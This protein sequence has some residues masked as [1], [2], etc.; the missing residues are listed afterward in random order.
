[1]QVVH[2][3]EDNAGWIYLRT[4]LGAW[5]MTSVIHY[6]CGREDMRAASLGDTDDWNVP[7]VEH[8]EE[9]WESMELVA[10]IDNLMTAAYRTDRMGEAAK[11][12]FGLRDTG[13]D[14]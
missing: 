9:D 8:T 1:M 5:D 2:V 7:T 10:W 4:D 6:E 14:A 13:T 3:Y 12:Y 11:T